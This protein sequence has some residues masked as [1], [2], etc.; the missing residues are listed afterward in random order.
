MFIGR[1]SELQFLNDAYESEKSE[2]IVLYGRRRVGKTE[3]LNEFCKNKDAIF[4]TCREY[5]DSMQLKSFTQKVKTHNIPSLGFV[6]SFSSWEHAFSSV[7]LLPTEKKKLLIIDEFPY[8]CK[9]NGSI[10]SILQV[11][12][13]EKLRYENVMI[14]IAGYK[15]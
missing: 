15:I 10:P 8:A 12:W 6:E 1:K 13:D 7:L 11:L 2:F 9:F 4:Y 5:T 3:L 14:S